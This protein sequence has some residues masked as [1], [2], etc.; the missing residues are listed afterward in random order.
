MNLIGF[1]SDFL[2]YFGPKTNLN[3]AG[4]VYFL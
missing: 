3:F 2:A 4:I 1:F